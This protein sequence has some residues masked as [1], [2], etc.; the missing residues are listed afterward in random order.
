MVIVSNTQNQSFWKSL[1]Q[2][3]VVSF[4]LTVAIVAGFA[5]AYSLVKP[6]INEALPGV[7]ISVA[8]IPPI[9]VIGYGLAHLDW[10]IMN[11]AGR[12]EFIF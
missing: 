9:A 8:L 2:S 1:G 6:Q 10:S 11:G 12:I 5:A 4:M 3:F 7:A